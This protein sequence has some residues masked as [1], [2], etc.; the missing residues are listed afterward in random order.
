MLR[1]P[2]PSVSAYP[3]P[4]SSWFAPSMSQ[5]IASVPGS[6]CQ[7]AWVGPTGVVPGD[8]YP[9]STR[10]TSW[11]LLIGHRDGPSNGDVL[12]G[13]LRIGERVGLM[14]VLLHEALVEGEVGEG[15]AGA[16]VARDVRV[17]LQGVEEIGGD[18]FGEVDRPLL[19][20]LDHRLGVLEELIDDPVDRRLPGVGIR[21]LLHRHRLA[22]LPVG[23]REGTRHDGVRVVVERLDRRLIA[24]LA[25]DV[26]GEDRDPGRDERRHAR[27]R[28]LPHERRVVR[29]GDRVDVGEVVREGGE[30][31]VQ[32]QVVGERDI[33]GGDRLAVAPGVRRRG[34]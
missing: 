15:E 20:R 30:V 31:V 28:R 24:E 25:P 26:L 32:D 34:S 10:S 21:D 8:P 16:D 6:Q 12:H 13:R 9:L 14:T 22:L 17:A 5:A 33:G 1:I 7:N 2:S 23:E 18:L 27:S 29:S 19:Q 3:A 4:S 11:S